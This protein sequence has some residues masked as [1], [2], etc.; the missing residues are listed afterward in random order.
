LLL[1]PHAKVLVA[2]PLG[3]IFYTVRLPASIVLLFWFVIQIFS[4]LVSGSQDS[5]AWGAHV[6]GFV[7]GMAL[8]PLFKDKKHRFFSSGH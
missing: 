3:I 5:V 6:G 7:C 1:Y 2:I 8:I 4:N